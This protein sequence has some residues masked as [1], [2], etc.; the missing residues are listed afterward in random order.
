MLVVHFPPLDFR[1]FFLPLQK[2]NFFRTL[3]PV[4]FFSKMAILWPTKLMIRISRFYTGK[5]KTC[6]LCQELRS[7][8]HR[9]KNPGHESY[10]WNKRY[11]RTYRLQSIFKCRES[12][13]EFSNAEQFRM[14]SIS[15]CRA[16][17]NAQRFLKAQHCQKQIISEFISRAF[18]SADHNIR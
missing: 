16:F 11:V 17:P 3:S 10:D 4:T 6:M 8:Y 13:L 18:P 15:E 7:F 12:L 2:E 9:K 1:S 14:Q 5:L